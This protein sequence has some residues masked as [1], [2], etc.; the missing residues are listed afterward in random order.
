MDTCSMLKLDIASQG[1]SI[2]DAH[3]NLQ[4]AVA[5][6]NNERNHLAPTPKPIIPTPGTA[7]LSLLLPQPSSSY[8]S[9]AVSGNLRGDG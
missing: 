3:N 2:K 5:L 4:Q 1:D 8:T 9:P 7:F 6:L